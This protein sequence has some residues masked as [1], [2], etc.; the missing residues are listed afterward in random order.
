MGSKTG[1]STFITYSVISLKFLA[2]MV[3][4]EKIIK[5]IR[6]KK[7]IKLLLFTD[8]M[9]LYTENPNNLQTIKINKWG[10]HS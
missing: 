3:K 4:Q 1:M 5:D 9:I 6:S 7:D 2:N 10:Q 8:D